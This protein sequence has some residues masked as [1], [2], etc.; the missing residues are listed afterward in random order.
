VKLGI[1]FKVI[2]PKRIERAGLWRKLHNEEIRLRRIMWVGC[3]A[4]MGK[5]RNI[6]KILVREHGG[7]RP[8]GGPGHYWEDNIKIDITELGWKDVDYIHE[9]VD[10]DLQWTLMSTVVNPLVP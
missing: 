9:S 1:C 3:A 8:L 5:M 10:R 4:C 2:V 7:T 6:C